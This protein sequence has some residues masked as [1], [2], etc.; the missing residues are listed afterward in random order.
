MGSSL[1]HNLSAAQIDAGLVSIHASLL[2][3]KCD[4]RAASLRNDRAQAGS[5]VVGTWRCRL[6]NH[7]EHH[8]T[9]RHRQLLVA[10]LLYHQL[11]AVLQTLLRGLTVQESASKNTF[12]DQQLNVSYA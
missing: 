5:R 9:R 6:C 8:C 7:G 10:R 2:V 12:G 3:S 11:R 4:L 1:Q